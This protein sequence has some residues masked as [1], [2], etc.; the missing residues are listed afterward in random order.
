V[1]IS[2]VGMGRVPKMVRS[3]VATKLKCL[4]LHEVKSGNGKHFRVILRR[5][6]QPNALTLQGRVQ[7]WTD[8]LI[9]L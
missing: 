2:R 8:M 5:C 9:F 4:L 7:F 6:M 1:K 3:D